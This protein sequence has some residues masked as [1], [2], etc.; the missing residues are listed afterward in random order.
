MKKISTILF[1]LTLIFSCIIATACDST[2]HN[3]ATKWTFDET[4]HW[5]ACTDEDC[6]AKGEYAEHVFEN[7]ECACGAF[8]GAISATPQNASSVIFNAEDNQIILLSKGNY[9]MFALSTQAKGVR[10]IFEKNATVS[11]LTIGEKL[12]DITIENLNFNGNLVIGAELDGFT[13]K[14][15][16]FSGNVQIAS[17][18]TEDV[19][20]KDIVIDNCRFVDISA[21]SSG[22]L[23]A[24]RLSRTENFTLTN[25]VF[26]NVQYNCIQMSGGIVGGGNPGLIGNIKIT[27]NTF[28]DTGVRALNLHLIDATTCDISGNIF[29]LHEF[30]HNGGYIDTDVGARGV[31]IGVNTW[32]FIPEGSEKNFLGWDLGVY[33]YDPTEQLLLD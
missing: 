24:I 31:V 10:L 26:D 4:H 13:L 28:K 12:S 25:C 2:E 16:N 1:C 7:S 32:E 27:G 8:E 6:N 22:K 3:F 20:L 18:T 33:T 5:K 30:S 21:G 29:Y 23:T 11:L 9:G 14:G 19:W 17:N 15:C